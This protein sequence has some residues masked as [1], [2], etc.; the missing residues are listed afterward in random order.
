MILQ[1]YW[2]VKWGK[3]G[4]SGHSQI[5]SPDFD[6][7]A[8]AKKSNERAVECTH[9]SVYLHTKAQYSGPAQFSDN[10]FHLHDAF[11]RN[12]KGRKSNERFDVVELA[13]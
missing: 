12:A 9:A 11:S 2:P 13:A 7:Y 4:V 5:Q 3:Y 6:V 1:F 8:L 10:K